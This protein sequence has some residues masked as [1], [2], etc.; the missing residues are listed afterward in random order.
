MDDEEQVGHDD[1]SMAR[2]PRLTPEQMT[3]EQ[4]EVAAEIAAGPRGEVRGPFIALIHNPEL[5][6]RVQKLG[7]YLRWQGKLPP[8][9]KELAVLV[10]ARRWTCQHEW[11]MH[12][13]L[14]LE[15]GLAPQVV[16]AI[17]LGREPVGMSE[18]EKAVYTFC[19]EAHATGRVGEEAFAAIKGRF[20]LDGALELLALNGYYTLMAMVLNSAGLPLPGN[21]E[22]PLK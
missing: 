5:A 21:V 1:L 17:K 2:F 10:T 15:G 3:P 6:R 7:E 19:R 13:K 9:L 4:Q 14:A 22:P 8:H 11:V 16:E 18:E 20:G 12:S